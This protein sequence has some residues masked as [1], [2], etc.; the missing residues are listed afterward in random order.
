MIDCDSD[1]VQ[2]FRKL[3][4]V[5]SEEHLFAETWDGV[6]LWEALRFPFF[7]H[8]LTAASIMQSEAVA[9]RD[10]SVT[11]RIQRFSRSVLMQFAALNSRGRK[12]DYVFLGPGVSRMRRRYDFFESAYFSR[13]MEELGE[14]NCILV[15]PGDKP[16]VRS[17]QIRHSNLIFSSSVIAWPR[18]SLHL[19]IKNAELLSAFRQ[20]EIILEKLSPHY[21]SVESFRDSARGHIE[22]FIVNRAAYKKFLRKHD[23]KFVVMLTSYGKE[24]IIAACQE[25]GIPSVELQH[26]T[27][28]HFSAQY[29]YP[30]GVTKTLFPDYFLSYSNYF[31]EI[32]EASNLKTKV[33]TF[34]NPEMENSV[35]FAN[36]NV[37]KKKILVLSQWTVRND[38]LDL[39]LDLSRMWSDQ[40]EIVF[41]LH[42][43]EAKI[44]SCVE[45]LFGNT[46]V[47]VAD[48]SDASLSKMQ[49]DAEFQVG[50]YS[51]A[52]FEGMALGCKT[53]VLDVAGVDH[54]GLA[55]EKGWIKKIR[56]AQEFDPTETFTEFLPQDA[57]S[58]PR[59]EVLSTVFGDYGNV[60]D[61]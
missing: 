32:L 22:N 46:A 3:C 41:R 31:T 47:C 17:R 18:L 29:F 48:Q 49:M 56:N 39:T 43:K 5:E 7:Q 12:R 60:R 15:E 9:P 10:P 44:R 16:E 51:T 53:F 2:A 45:N 52:L 26:G 33:I 14:N 25:L 55:I 34:G 38:L 35:F 4:R 37:K 36:R 1:V 19:G 6:P 58:P 20:L 28:S 57:M 40:Y 11:A 54:V 42:P 21:R 13:V 59:L 61:Y 24:G 50:V 23:P 27:I 8:S 30:P